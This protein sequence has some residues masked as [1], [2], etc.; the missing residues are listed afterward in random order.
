[1]ILLD[2]N[3]L[4]RLANRS[5]ADYQA[6]HAAISGCKKNGQQLG[7]VD[8]N[9]HEFWAAATRS[10]AKN[11]MGMTPARANSFLTVYLRIFVR[12]ADP[13]NLFVEW[14]ALVN[15]LGIT[16]IQ[17]YDA[18]L[19]AVVKTLSLRGLMTYNIKHFSSLSV[20]IIDPRDSSSW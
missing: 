13:A 9:L 5:D 2:T 15:A 4:I 20:T 18:R 17:A 14:R 7:V 10:V 1:M 11:G 16:G 19:A 8:Q 12:I 3:I 6:T